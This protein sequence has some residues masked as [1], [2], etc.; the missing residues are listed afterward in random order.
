QVQAATTAATGLACFIF[1]FLR[2]P[3]KGPTGADHLFWRTTQ[4]PKADHRQGL[5]VALQGGGK[6]RA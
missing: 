1:R 3:Q 4:R 5:G 6:C 2:R